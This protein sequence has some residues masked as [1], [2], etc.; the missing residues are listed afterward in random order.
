MPNSD[1]PN[2]AELRDE[3]APEIQV[4][5]SDQVFDGR[6]WDLRRE[7]VAYGD[8]EL[9]REFVDHPGAVGVVALDEDDR[10]LLIQQYRHAVA[11]REWEIPAGLMDA[12][13]ESGL[14]TAKR[15]LEEEA[16][17]A[18]NDWHLLADTY[19]TPGGS[20]ECVRVFL[21]RDLR[22]VEHSFER[23]GEESDMRV[24]WV[25]LEEAVKAVLERRMHNGVLVSA[26][27][28]VDAARRLNW[29]TLGDP[30]EPWARREQVRGNRVRA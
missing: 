24:E 6:I 7:R 16:D 12:P 27:L 11:V 5:E 4:R 22:S 13:H 26:I 28:A 25:P 18:A 17:L 10:V 8:S 30:N 1:G 19:T 15:E 21:A 29:Q 14:E 23:T 9:V 3:P 20:T 2:F